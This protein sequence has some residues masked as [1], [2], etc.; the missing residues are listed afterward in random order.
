[1]TQLPSPSSFDLSAA[2]ESVLRA[3]NAPELAT[4]ALAD[5]PELV[6]AL[7]KSS[8]AAALRGADRKSVKS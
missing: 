4:L 6:R 8:P 7:A 1:M 3:Q 2:T 5:K